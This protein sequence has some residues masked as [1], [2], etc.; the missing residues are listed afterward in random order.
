MENYDKVRNSKELL[1]Q[2]LVPKPTEKL[3]SGLD[4]MEN[5]FPPYSRDT[6]ES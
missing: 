4:Q 6:M 3:L 5:S 1:A 2:N